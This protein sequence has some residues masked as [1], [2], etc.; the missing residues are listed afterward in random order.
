MLLGHRSITMLPSWKSSPHFPARPPTLGLFQFYFF[1]WLS[2]FQQI[3]NGKALAIIS[4]RIGIGNFTPFSEANLNTLRHQCSKILDRKLK[5]I[6]RFPIHILPFSHNVYNNY[7]PGTSH[8]GTP[9]KVQNT[10][11]FE[12]LWLFRQN[13]L[14]SARLSYC[15]RK[16]LFQLFSIKN[17]CQK[18]LVYVKLVKIT[19]FGP[20]DFWTKKLFAHKSVVLTFHVC[21]PSLE[22]N[23]C[24]EIE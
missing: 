7:K 4:H 14:L 22:T 3:G 8:V 16:I 15:I 6:G 21:S 19:S 20:K 12:K 9:R 11:A 13:E 18:N 2:A 5:C 24:M 1:L 17:L 10:H 23:S